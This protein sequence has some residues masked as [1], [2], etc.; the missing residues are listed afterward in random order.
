MDQEMRQIQQHMKNQLQQL[1]NRL[2]Y[3]IKT[4][5]SGTIQ[6]ISQYSDI[7]GQKR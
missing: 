7:N 1:H 6:T 3:P 5:E 4:N 2:Q